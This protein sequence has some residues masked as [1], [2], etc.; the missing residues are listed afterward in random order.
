MDEK[1]IMIDFLSKVKIRINGK[2]YPKEAFS[3][4]KDEQLLEILRADDMLYEAYEAY[5][6]EKETESRKRST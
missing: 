3:Y 6:L 4:L 2:D 5:R 1:E